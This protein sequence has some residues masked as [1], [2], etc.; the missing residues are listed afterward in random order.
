M[1]EWRRLGEGRGGRYWRDPGPLGRALAV[2]SGDHPHISYFGTW[3][4]GTHRELR[5]AHWDGTDWHDIQIVEQSTTNYV[6]MYNSIAVDSS[7]RPRIAYCDWTPKD[8][9]YA[10]WISGTTWGIQTVD[11]ASTVRRCSLALDADGKAHIAYEDVTAS[12]YALK[13]ARQT[14]GASWSIETVVSNGLL[15]SLALD[16]GDYPHIAYQDYATKN[17]RYVAWNGTGW[18]S[19]QTVDN[20]TT[21]PYPCLALG[22]GDRPG[23]AYGAGNVGGGDL[24]YAEWN[25]TTWDIELVETS[26]VSNQDVWLAFT[27][28]GQPC[29]SFYDGLFGDPLY[30]Y[31]LWASS[32]VPTAVYWPSW[33]VI[34]PE[35]PIGP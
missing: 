32:A 23:I 14:D 26:R 15:P 8:L 22:P 1:V 21:N 34:G 9:K 24:K 10:T 4:P 5:Y 6:G 31:V 2:D 13:Y 28:G 20:S 17:L 12:A 25:G 18:D 30:G 33:G 29:I 35:G 16:S 3:Q 19:P 7:N 27:S 11:S